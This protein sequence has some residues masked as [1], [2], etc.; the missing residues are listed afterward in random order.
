VPTR[1]VRSSNAG[2]NVKELFD[3]NGGPNQGIYGTTGLVNQAYEHVEEE[4]G[5]SIRLTP[6]NQN[7]VTWSNNQTNQRL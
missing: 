1:P 4:D 3:L 2:V 7:Q 6:R 5:N